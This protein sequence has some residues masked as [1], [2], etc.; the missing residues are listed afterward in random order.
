MAATV[1]QFDH[2]GATGQRPLLTGKVAIITGVGQGIGRAA[3][4]LFTEAGAAVVGCD[5]DEAA[6]AAAVA[7]LGPDADVSIVRGDV[8]SPVDMAALADEAVKRHGRIDVLYNN[9]GVGT[10]ADVPTMLHLT[11]DSIWDTTID[12][13]LKGTFLA[14][15]AVL[16]HMLATGGSIVNVASVYA[17][18]A[19]PAAPSYAASKGGVIAL[20]RSLAVDYAE[21]GIRANVICPGF[22]ATEM[23]LGYVEKLEDPIASRT[24]IDA[25]HLL[26]RLAQPE[27]IAAAALW[28]S[29]DAA[30]F[31]TGAV[32]AVDGGYTS[33]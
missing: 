5:L 33:R 30:S 25:A 32:L 21:S 28:L 7:A 31:V 6:G 22:T 1:P 23:V 17:L 3:M 8:T 29:S 10:I 27:E 16:P 4:R 11:P 19:G 14:C 24:E 2:L 18:V 15:K 9:A 12:V 26:G 20:T 13:N